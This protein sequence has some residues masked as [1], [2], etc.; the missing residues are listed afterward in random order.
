MSNSKKIVLGVIALLVGAFFLFDLGRFLELSVLK[1]QQEQL[2]ELIEANLLLSLALLF[3]V[4]V[5]VTALSLPGAAVM[6]LA[7]GALFGFGWGLLVI[8]FASTVGA[9]LAFLVA[10][11]LFRDTLRER[12][13]SYLKKIDDG[14]QRDGAFYLAT[15][16]LIPVFPFFVINIVLGLTGMKTWTFYWVS[17]LA[18]LPGTA[19]FVNAGTQLAQIE[20]MGDIVSPELLLSFVLLGVFPLIAKFVVGRIQK[21]RLYAHYDKPERFDYNMVVIGG[22]SAGLVSAYIGA[23]VNARVALIERGKMGGDCLNTGCV[24]S[25]A[26]IRSA[27][28]AQNMREADRYGLTAAEPNI[29]F[30]NVMKRIHNVIKTIEPHDSVERFTSL[31]VDC[32]QGSARFVSPWEVEVDEDGAK[33]RITAKSVVIATGGKPF[34][35]PIPGIEDVAP[36]TSENLWELEDQ[37]GRLVVLGGGPIGSELSQAFSRLGTQV[38]QIEMGDRLLPREDADV[39]EL[40]LKRFRDEGVDVRLD[41]RASRFAVEDGERVVYCEHAGDTVRIPFDRVLVAVGRKG[42]TE[43]LGLESLGI[44]PGPQG[45]LPTND[46]LS[47]VFPNIFACGDVAGPYQ[48][49]HMAAHQAW[50]AAVN[51]LFGQF[52]RFSVDYSVTPWVTFTSPEVGRVGLNETEAREQGIDYEVTTYGLDDLDRAIAESE[53]HGFIKVITRRGK[54][55]ILG[56]TVAGEHGGELLTEFILAM[57]H[58]IGLNKILGTIHP[59]PTWNESVKF[60]AGEWKKAHA[61]QK[62][63]QWLGRYHRRRLKS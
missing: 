30:A 56:A 13:A 24:P 51:A 21:K 12:Y 39:S 27:K 11:F 25:K 17:Q 42:N 1:A 33:R 59:Y 44:E 61:P 4:Y 31:G 49:T 7:G 50:H 62:V 35:P 54:D 29:P 48:F 45:T 52:K 10:R 16:R 34:V 2:S 37:P 57:K 6:T 43:G 38:I 47:V 55:R 19:V 41:H 32:V 8:S 15:L 26:L 46:D 63:I 58:G 40:V 3:V 18:M 5:A 60:A 9:T 36:L 20:R 53:D 22:G 28:V 23:T 14:I